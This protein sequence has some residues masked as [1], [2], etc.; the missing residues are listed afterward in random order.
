MTPT[1]Q[2]LYMVLI[3]TITDF[4]IIVKMTIA[5]TIRIGEIRKGATSFSA[6][7]NWVH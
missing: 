2:S 3:L 4:R 1:R 5:Q 7:G 6:P